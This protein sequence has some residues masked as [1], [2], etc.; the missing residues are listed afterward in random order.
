MR[1]STQHP[2]SL[3][4]VGRHASPNRHGLARVTVAVA[5]A[6]ISDLAVAQCPPAW[7][8][9]DGFDMRGSQSFPP[10]MG[11]LLNLPNGDLFASGNFDMAG[12]V[13]G[14]NGVARWNGSVW[15]NLGVPNPQTVVGVMP[16]G[17]L[18]GVSQL[19]GGS[20]ANV[21]QWNGSTWIPMGGG[22]SWLSSYVA[23]PTLLPLPNGDVIAGGHFSLAGG[24]PATNVARWD[25]STSTW[26]PM[27][28][29]V[30]MANW[31]YVQS[32]AADANGNVY[33]A[34]REFGAQGTASV[35]RWD[36]TAWSTIGTATGPYGG[37]EVASMAVLPNGSLVIGGQFSS[38]NST[39]ASDLA[40]WNGASWSS[41]GSGVSGQ[42]HAVFS[43]RVVS[44]GDLLVGGGFSQVDGIQA[45]AIARWNGTSW[46]SLGAG[47]GTVT[48]YPRV[49]SIIER[50]SGE[51]VAAGLIE[52]AGG[53]PSI[54][55]AR[56]G[57]GANLASYSSTGSGCYQ[58]STFES[59]YQD[60]GTGP[61]D[62]SQSSILMMPT[63]MG[64][65][66][67]PASGAPPFVPPASSP[68]WMSDDHLTGSIP[69]GFTLPFPGGSTNEIFVSSNG[70]LFLQ[71]G[72][73]AS[74]FA[75]QVTQLLNGAPR[76]APMWGDLDPAFPG[77]GSGSVHVDL[78]A[79]NQRAYVTWLNIQEW[80]QPTAISTFQVV[81]NASGAIE[82]RFLNCAMVAAPVLTGWSP[83]GGVPNPGS[84]DLSTAAPFQT[85]PHI[86]PLL[87]AATTRPGLGAAWHLETRQIP[88]S[89]V[90]GLE[91]LGLANPNIPDLAAIGAAGC[92]I[93]ATLE[94]MNPFFPVGGTH[95]WTLPIPNSSGLIGMHVH[96]TSAVWSLPPPN[97]LG[98][99]TANGL[100]G[101]LG[102]P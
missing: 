98:I 4:Q 65:T 68:L 73:N 71:P 36:G 42:N 99:I 14:F 38:V 40:L 87:Q 47:M 72:G 93:Y 18:L 10:Q 5:L 11:R 64:Y 50:P 49:G 30:T 15:S 3:R 57:C 101:E 69:L 62:L 43:L 75:G 83:G 91:I 58:S 46:S 88:A 44:N 55:I 28:S 90:L 20:V 19:V 61:F 52:A 26:L 89:G 94:S 23:F 6:A 96:A 54:G 35:H 45:S 12:G 27:G 9:G 2:A 1:N 79:V 48:Y 92:G 67:T 77:T 86:L 66:V 81:L 17:N 21:L 60:F 37:G 39:P 100:D 76:L 32:L 13:A 22:L 34:L 78:D 24:V 25:A 56:W 95:S 16:N 29:G 41:F 7:L 74:V 84:R 59:Y 63:A 80:G 102:L 82:Y 53:Q 8:P 31:C 51:I 97:A 33:A 70:C 85:L